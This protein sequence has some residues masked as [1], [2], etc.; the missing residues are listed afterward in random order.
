M[1]VLQDEELLKMI[2]A[3]YAAGTPFGGTSAGA[4]VMSDPRMTGE[5]D[6]KILDGKRVGVRP[7]TRD[8]AWTEAVE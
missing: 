1:D 4:A 2:R 6:L 8:Q 3:R 7:A 5:A